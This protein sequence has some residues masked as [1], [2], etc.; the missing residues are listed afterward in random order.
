MKWRVECSR[1]HARLQTGY[2]QQCIL[3]AGHPQRILAKLGEK[4]GGTEMH[5]KARQ[6]RTHARRA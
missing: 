5:S 2:P 6:H 1:R 4:S 3:T